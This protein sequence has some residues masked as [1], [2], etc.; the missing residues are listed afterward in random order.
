VGCAGKFPNKEASVWCNEAGT[1][2]RFMLA[3]CAAIP[4]TYHFDAAAQL[5]ARPLSLLIKAL[6]LQGAKF[7]PADALEMP[8]TLQG[9]E[10]F[11]GGEI[12]IDASQSGQFV[13][14]LLMAAPFAASAF[15]IRVEDLVSVPY[16]DMTCAIMAEF[17]VLVQQ[18]HEGF[19]RVLV[20]QHYRG[21]SYVIEPDLSTASYFFAAAAVTAGNM[22]VPNIDRENS[23]QGDIQFLKVLEKMGCS[24]TQTA[25]GI[26]VQGVKELQGV[27]VD[28]RDFSDTFMTLAAIAPF[29]NSPT[30]ITN[31]RHARFQE[32]DRLSA[33]CDVLNKLNIKTEMGPDWLRV[34]PGTPVAAEIDS[35]KDHRIAMSAAIIGL[36]VPGVIINNAECVAKTCPE[37][38]QMWEQL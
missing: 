11:L 14:A 3:M 24:V 31:I 7:I 33:M 4:G 38:F 22:T 23:K 21:L 25:A 35:H 2:A 27:D 9:A 15:S 10:S 19:Y 26:V 29:A 37:F 18:M 8:F 17:G 16:V 12:T 28:M 36:R 6:I 34:Y 5:R 13:S 1:V 30:T 32:S 20:P